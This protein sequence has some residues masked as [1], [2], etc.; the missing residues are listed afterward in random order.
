[1]LAKLRNVLRTT[2]GQAYAPGADR[3]SKLSAAELARSSWAKS[4][5]SFATLPEVYKDFF[6]SFQ[7]G[8]RDFPYTLLI[9]SHERF[10]YRAPEKLI[11]DFGQEIYILEKTGNTYITVCYPLEGISYVEFKTAL[12]A[13]SIKICGQAS[14]GA[15]TSS[16]LI[17]NSVT[18]YL[19]RPIL[20]T[21]R[22]A[23]ENATKI[24]EDSQTDQF[25]HLVKVN[26]KFMNYARY[27]LIGGEKVIG[28]ILQPEI[29]A[30]LLTVLK[31]T[32][33]RTISPTHMTILTDRELI[34]IREDATRRKEDR[35]GGIRDYISLG[36]IV[37]L[38]LND[39]DGSLSKL[40]IQL[41]GNAQLELLFQAS[42]REGV[43]R[44]LDRFGELTNKMEQVIHR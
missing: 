1:M 35:Y 27:S 21:I 15:Y 41:P 24:S 2:G 9:P 7:T 39:K 37:S 43:N 13:S 26:F 31:K 14:N 32:Y 8:G 22:R 40:T 36:K 42:A 5:E 10:I 18:D 28:F 17:F 25:D 12:L 23:D 16:T 29:Q 11:C 20:N 19:F 38:S 44:L 33:Y 3:L 34:V 4:I 30:R 6:A